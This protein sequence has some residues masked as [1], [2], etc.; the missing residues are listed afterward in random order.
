MVTHVR[1]AAELCQPPE[2]AAILLWRSAA[3]LLTLLARRR[4]PAGQSLSLT[5]PTQTRWGFPVQWLLPDQLLFLPSPS[6]LPCRIRCP[7]LLRVQTFSDAVC[8]L[9]VHNGDICAIVPYTTGII[10]GA[11]QYYKLSLTGRA[12]FPSLEWS[13]KWHYDTVLLQ[14]VWQV[15]CSVFNYLHIQYCT[16]TSFLGP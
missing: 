10:T 4:Q 8:R 11:I 6:R 9:H 7:V 12:A 15:S 3:Q 13:L 2:S 14:Y 16:I 1:L 5:P